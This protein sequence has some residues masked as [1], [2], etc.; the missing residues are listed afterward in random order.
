MGLLFYV[1]LI[2]FAAGSLLNLFLL[3]LI[4][5]HRRPRTFERVLFF[6]VLALFLFYSGALL[7]QNAFIHYASPPPATLIFAFGLIGSG[8][9]MLPPLLVHA[10]AQYDRTLAA[11]RWPGWMKA[12]VV[13]FYLPLAYFLPQ[14]Y[15]KIL[16]APSL[17]FLWPGTST[18]NSYGIWMGAA[19]LA[20]FALQRRAI[21]QASDEPQRRLHVAFAV[22]FGVAGV[23][24]LYVY[25]LGGPHSP[26]W[27]AAFGTAVVL[28]ALVPAAVLGYYVLR[29]NFLQIGLQ[30]NL[31]YA[32]SAS[33]LAL[34]YLAAVRRVSGWLEPV[35]PPEATAS[36]LLF[37]LVFAFEPL[38]RRIGRGLQRTLHQQ[39]ERL[40]R[41]SAELQQEVRRGQLGE[42]LAVAEVR[43]REEFGLAEV[44]IILAGGETSGAKRSVSG[45]R[46]SVRL[47]LRKGQEEI[48]WLEASAYGAFV[49]G[50]TYAALEFLAEQL[51]ATL[52]LCRLIEEKLILERELAEHERLALVGQMAAS[53]SHNLRNPL[54]SMKTVLQ[55]LLENPNLSDDVRRD[56]GLVVG[57]IDRL[58]AKLGQLLRFAKP[59]VRPVAR[60]QRVDVAVLA[61]QIVALLGRDATRRNIALELTRSQPEL[62]VSGSE[63]A[64]SDVL[65]NLVVNAIEALSRGGCVRV[66]LTQRDG[67]VILEVNDDGPGIPPV[68]RG[69]I[70]QPFF[71]TKSSG[72]GLGLAIVEKRVL[73]MGATIRWESPVSNGR[74]TKFTVT[75]PLPRNE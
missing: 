72:T 68:L 42:L 32:V 61:E 25:T 34:L 8:M 51:P 75:L 47:P 40:Q 17:E 44:R 4:V 50:D 56:C 33:F 21:L 73:E 18:L 69:K 10:E 59:P 38:Q 31:V 14:V 37:V 52:D 26:V 9:A 12:F 28:S 41:L 49:S 16:M 67:R 29:Y 24:T 6:L 5:G 39:M 23:L 7:G 54:S 70:F 64:L 20:C 22:F 3:A 55:V 58:A 62:F 36:V 71:T 27:S 46:S 63:E 30:R 35:L 2:G 43:I 19:L 74:G 65:S 66:A 57:E 15:P 60:K 13:A 1:R 11:A 45:S 53:I 48:G